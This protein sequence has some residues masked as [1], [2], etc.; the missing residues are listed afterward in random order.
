MTID[1]FTLVAQLANFLILLLL[2]RRFLYEPVLGVMKRREEGIEGRFHEAERSRREADQEAERL[3]RERR[4]L[5]ERREELIG[6]ARDEA[7]KRRSELLDE[8]RREVAQERERWLEDLQREGAAVRRALRLGT[9]REALAAS[10]KIL[11]EL[12]SAELEES[13]VR[14]FLARVE[15]M[16]DDK[17]ELLSEALAVEEPEVVVRTAFELQADHR[18]R[19][20]RALSDAAGGEG[21]EVRFERDE[22][23]LL[24]L[25]VEA[26]GRL[27]QWSAD[28][29]LDELGEDVVG[30]LGYG[31]DEA[32][33]LEAL[34]PAVEGVGR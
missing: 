10:R 23:L 28:H 20:I 24:G 16:D 29:Y 26:E 15:E 33:G 18:Q 2:L 25:E 31:D 5:E 8:A 6:E 7:Q 1:W 34:R 32:R 4:Q 13:A 30:L 22:A 27:I 12:A 17:R 3:R 11:A 14:C 19:I 9:A 21:F